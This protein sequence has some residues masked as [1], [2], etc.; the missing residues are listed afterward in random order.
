[1]EGG[2]D[3]PPRAADSKGQQNENLNEK[4]LFPSL[5]FLLIFAKNKSKSTIPPKKN[6]KFF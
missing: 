3:A 1:V 4:I 2:C 6:R 5:N